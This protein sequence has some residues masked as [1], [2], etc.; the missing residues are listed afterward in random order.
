[1]LDVDQDIFELANLYPRT[2][3]L[4]MTIWISPR[5]RAQHDVR[6]KVCTT[7][8]QRMDPTNPA[9]MAVRP[10]PRLIE[11]NLSA[12]DEEAVARWINLN[13]EALVSIWEG[14]VD[15]TEVQWRKV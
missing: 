6:I 14:E 7:H 5:G 2:T 13:R 8:G 12:A 11:G 10:V 4:P 9:V 3:A 1:M 15:P